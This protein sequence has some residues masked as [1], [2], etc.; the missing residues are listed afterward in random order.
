M[1]EADAFVTQ[2]TAGLSSTSSVMTEMWRLF[3]FLDKTTKLKVKKAAKGKEKLCVSSSSDSNPDDQPQGEENKIMDD[4]DEK[5]EADLKRLAL[6][7]LDQVVDLHERLR[8]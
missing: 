6:Y 2:V 4:P 8:K 1:Q 7:V 5:Y 3:R